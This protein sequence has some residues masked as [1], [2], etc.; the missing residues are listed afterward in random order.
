MAE[1]LARIFG[2]EEDKVNC[3]FYFKIG[4]CRHGETCTR[5]HNKPPMSQT[6]VF[7]HLYENPPAAV[8]FAS[9]YKVPDEELV[10]AV[11]HFQDFYEEVFWELAKFGELEDLVVADNIGDH[12]IGNV[13]AKFNTE[14]QAKNAMNGLNGRYYAGRHISAEF[15]PVT[16]FKEA[17]C[18][19][20]ADGHCDRGGHCNFMH[21]KH[22]SK[23]L[24]KGLTKL[25]YQ[26]Y[27]DYKAAKTLREQDPEFVPKKSRSRS[28][29]KKI[30]RKPDYHRHDEKRDDRTR[31]DRGYEQKDRH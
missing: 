4:A 26:E 1:K 29:E 11:N 2:T 28:R 12:M 31:T 27:P 25:M 17:K 23:D 5:I 7:H 18:R 20:F 14:E 19:M 24:K 22:V 16:D 15:S 6:M 9:D 3:P 30:E 8:A 21:P 10:K 13:Y